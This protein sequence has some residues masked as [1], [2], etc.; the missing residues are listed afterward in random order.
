MLRSDSPAN[1][2]KLL[3]QLEEM[4]GSLETMPQRGHIPPELRRINISE[5]REIHCKVYRIIYQVIGSDIFVHCVLDGRRDIQ[6]MLQQ[7][8]SRWRPISP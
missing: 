1:A 4:I 5:Y 3:D 8:L 2:E 6:D 7:R